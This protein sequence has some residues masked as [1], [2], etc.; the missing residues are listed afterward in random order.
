MAYQ[1]SESALPYLQKEK[2]RRDKG[3]RDLMNMFMMQKQLGAER[4]E[5]E[6]ERGV[7]EEE[8]ERKFEHWGVLEDLQRA[9]A[10]KIRRPEVPEVPEEPEVPLYYKKAQDLVKEGLAKDIGEG[11]SMILK[12][13]QEPVDVYSRRKK[14]L[15]DA[16][17]LG[18]ITQEQHTQSLF[19]LKAGLTPEEKR[20]KGASFRDGNA[21][22]LRDFYKTIPG[23]I[24]N[25]GRIVSKKLRKI[26]AERG[27]G[28]PVSSQ[29]YR[30]DM[31]ERYNRAILNKRDGVATTENLDIIAKYEGMFRVFQDRLLAGGIDSFKKFITSA[32]TKDLRDDPNFDNYQIKLWYDIFRK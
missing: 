11:L 16:L 6:F 9:R 15:D 17:E 5:R 28:P 2:E 25:K 29:G 13:K 12:L 4:G 32:D 8:R 31:P 14:D 24:D 27:G 26:V 23:L 20:R 10:E 30:L 1:R 18:A 3:M 19:N 21:R 22:E 7:E